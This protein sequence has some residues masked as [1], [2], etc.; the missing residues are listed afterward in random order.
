MTLK[1]D[2]TEERQYRRAIAPKNDDKT[3]D[4]MER[5]KG[6]KKIDTV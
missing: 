2:D 3:N 6:T 5:R 1:N 4:D